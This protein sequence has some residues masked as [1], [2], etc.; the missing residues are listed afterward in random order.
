V[1]PLVLVHGGAHGAWCWA[2]TLELLSTPATAVDLPPKE[3]RR[4]GDARRSHPPELDTLTVGDFAASVLADMDAAGLDRAVLVGHSMG[5]LTIAEVASRAPERVAQLVFVSCIAPAE[6][7]AVLD[8]LPDDL[9][10]MTRDAT[11]A[12]PA[13]ALLSEDVIRVMFCN[14]MDK[15]QTQ[16]V[17]DHVGT[18]VMRPLVTPVVRRGVPAAIPKTY[19]RLLRDQ[20][21]PPA[22]QDEQIAN[23]RQS[24]GGDVEVIEIDSGHDVMIS[25]PAEFAAALDRIGAA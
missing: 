17:L 10:D 25:R 4:G 6:G 13:D 7:T 15:A 16:L 14:D 5:G 9:A 21:L 20:S 24:P 23:L 11:D 12:P 19:V 22:T 18:E 3:I 2:P 8:A 1:T